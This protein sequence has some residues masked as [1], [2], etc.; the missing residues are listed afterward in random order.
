[1]QDGIKLNITDSSV[2]GYSVQRNSDVQRCMHGEECEHL[3]N[4]TFEEDDIAK[5][6]GGKILK[7]M[8]C[9]FNERS[10]L[11][12]AGCP[13]G[14]WVAHRDYEGEDGNLTTVIKMPYKKEEKHE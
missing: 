14:K 2:D 8:D 10:I 9:K 3:D 1:M 5:A 6:L 11:E 7:T 13:L 12:I 4:V